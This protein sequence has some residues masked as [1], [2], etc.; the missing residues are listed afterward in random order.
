[1]SV[2]SLI[3]I[4]GFTFIVLID[5]WLYC[6]IGISIIAYLHVSSFSHISVFR[7]FKLL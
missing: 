4:R 6:G 5:N 7:T 2:R 3:K 1:M